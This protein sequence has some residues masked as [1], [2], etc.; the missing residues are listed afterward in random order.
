[1]FIISSAELVIG[2]CKAGIV[3]SC[4]ALNAR[5]AA[6]LDKWLA[7]ITEELAITF[8]WRRR[9]CSC[10]RLNFGKPSVRFFIGPENLADIIIS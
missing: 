6:Q 8:G 4:P 9:S 1:M 5:P 7:Q 10:A 3:G 2:Q